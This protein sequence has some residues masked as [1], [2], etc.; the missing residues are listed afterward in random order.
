M[1]IIPKEE[2]KAAGPT[3]PSKVEQIAAKPAPKKQAAAKPKDAK[4]QKE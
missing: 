2:I 1:T 4:A 3:N